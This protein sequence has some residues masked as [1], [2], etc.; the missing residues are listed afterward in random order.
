MSPHRRAEEGG[1]P[2]RLPPPLLPATGEGL[3]ST[4]HLLF[5][6]R[7]RQKERVS[8]GRRREEG[9]LS[10]PKEG[11]VGRGPP[12]RRGA[13]PKGNR[14][15]GPFFHLSTWRDPPPPRN[16]SSS[17]MIPDSC[18]RLAAP[19]P[20]SG[21]GVT[22]KIALLGP[23]T[24][25]GNDAGERPAPPGPSR[26]PLPHGAGGQAG[27]EAASGWGEGGPGKLFTGSLCMYFTGGWG[28]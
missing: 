3:R 4:S 17:V 18:A 15:R 10:P 25:T 20:R 16:P 11:G 26:R 8:Q 13:G 24:V 22:F 21:R 7:E 5:H 19:S 2:R 1:T 9:A 27:A 12:A 6:C 28:G 14:E 23:R